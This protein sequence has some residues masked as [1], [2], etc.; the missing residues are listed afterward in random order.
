VGYSESNL[1]WAV[2][3]TSNE[4]QILLYTRNT[5]ILQLLLKVVTAGTEAFVSG[6]NCLYASVKKV[7]RLWAQPRDTFHQVLINAEAL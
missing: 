6:N 3:K 1:R 7:C 5:Y 2:T 4:K